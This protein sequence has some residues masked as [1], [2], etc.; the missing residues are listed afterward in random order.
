FA[1][2]HG[3]RDVFAADRAFDDV[4]DVTDLQSIARGGFAVYIEIEEIAADLA[5]GERT[6]RVGHIS[7]FALDLHRE[8]LNFAKIRPENF[9]A[10]HA[11][12]TGGEHF[13]AR[14]DWHPENVR[15]AG[16]F[17]VGV[18]FSKQFFPCHP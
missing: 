14:L 8:L 9:Y 16:R 15:H 4:V 18:D 10:E 5:L 7:Q 1:P 6:P 2:F 11:A 13:N 3:G 17:D 12:E